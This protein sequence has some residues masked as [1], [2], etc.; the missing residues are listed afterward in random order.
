MIKKIILFVFILSIVSAVPLFAVGP[1]YYSDWKNGY[2]G[3]SEAVYHG[4]S[5]T[6]DQEGIAILK[7]TNEVIFKINRDA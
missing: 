3:Y 7:Q 2:S 6:V 5:D 4:T 1:K